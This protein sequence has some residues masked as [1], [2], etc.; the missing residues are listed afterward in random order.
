MRAAL[1]VADIFRHCGPQYRQTHAD[2]LSR[3]QRRAMSAIELCRT[4]ALGGHVEQCDACGHQRIAFNSCR[5]RACPK[6][7]SLARSQWLEDRQAELLPEV[8]YFHVVFTVPESIAALAYRN[9]KAFYDILFRAGAETLRTIAADPKHL[10]A[11]I[12]FIS[13]LH[14]W[15]QNLQHH[16]HVHC[17][18]PGGGL[19]P[20][21]ER[22]IACRPGFFLPVRVLSRLFGGARQVLDYMG[23]YTHRVAI[24]NHR[25]AAFD[26]NEVSFRWEDYKHAAVTKT[27]TLADDEFIRRFLLHILPSGFKH[28]RSYGLL[29]NRCRAAKLATCR[30][31]LGVAMPA[32]EAL[33]VPEDYR[34]RYQRLTG[35]SLRDCPACGRGHMVC[36]ETF[37]PGALP[38]PPPCA[39]PVH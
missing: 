11:A 10:G 12:G 31:L 21:R 18:V 32:A 4:A 13:I 14:T 26:G 20:D 24:S 28:I 16:P 9:K 19:A 7:Q 1:E 36:I 30:R 5:H 29:A 3:A 34:D 33:V 25:L 22:W 15:G 17:V 39:H 37:L 6:C 23:R 27:M 35:K 2:G 8:E 38:R